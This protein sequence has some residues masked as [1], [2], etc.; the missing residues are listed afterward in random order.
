LTAIPVPID[1]VT[2]YLSPQKQ[3]SV[4]QD[5]LAVRPRR[6]IFNPGA[7]NASATETLA[8]HGIDVVEACTLVL[9]S[10]GQ[11][12]RHAGR[13]DDKAPGT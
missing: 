11:F 7:E 12:W 13:D 5:I 6:V 2:V 1:T 3:A 10:T 8:R 9:L 4:I